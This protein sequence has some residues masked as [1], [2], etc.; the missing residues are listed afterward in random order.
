MLVSLNFKMF[1]HTFKSCL[2]SLVLLYVMPMKCMK[3]LIDQDNSVK[4]QKIEIVVTAQE[5]ANDHLKELLKDIKAPLIPALTGNITIAS[6]D[7]AEFS[8][9]ASIA[10]LS[11]TFKNLIKDTHVNCNNA[12][13]AF[14]PLSTVNEKELSVIVESLKKISAIGAPEDYGKELA[15][16]L[17]PL[18]KDLS[19]TD[20]VKL[21]RA[22]NYLNIKVLLDYTIAFV[23]SKLQHYGNMNDLIAMLQMLDDKNV[24]PVELQNLLACKLKAINKKLLNKLPGK[25]LKRFGEPN[26]CSYGKLSYDG[27][28][29]LT[30]SGSK[31][32]YWDLT[33]GTIIRDLDG[34]EGTIMD[35]AISPDGTKALTGSR[36]LKAILW[37]LSD[38][39]ILKTL[40]G[41]TD[42]IRCVVFRPDG[43]QALTT[44]EDTTA[45]LWDLNTGECV[46]EITEHNDIVSTA[47][48]SCDANF[49]VT[50]SHDYTA[51]LWD[52]TIGILK[53]SL[54]VET[55][56]IQSVAIT[57]NNRYILIGS[58]ENFAILWDIMSEQICY[59]L[60]GHEDAIDVVTA[61]PDGI[62][63]LTGSADSSVIMWDLATLT[64][65][66]KI[67]HLEPIESIAISADSKL[68]LISSST[69]SVLWSLFGIA[70]ELTL[71]QVMLILKWADN[72]DT[73]VNNDYFN[74]IFNNTSAEVKAAIESLFGPF[75][76]DRT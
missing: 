37:N 33:T 55:A 49:A 68:V 20:L 31:A 42:T 76:Q 75:K 58:N 73:V 17:D 62:Y 8:I 14:F 63:A 60:Q 40:V 48:F 39:T 51:I 11:Q 69:I 27:K 38:G 15:Q 67:Q 12:N 35:L 66:K 72:K 34:H 29:A 45:R 10:C 32:Y 2:L 26:K 19:A 7:E 36:D 74:K 53:S 50:G 71:P 6:Q 3:R 64:A 5:T 46:R 1:N 54:D 57:P 21:L 43:N 22:I 24:I 25:I 59:N 70:D 13:E 47:V 44:S 18:F 16:A 28:Y 56:G 52:L 41:H 30:A 65:I 4:K 9:P 61:S 23:A